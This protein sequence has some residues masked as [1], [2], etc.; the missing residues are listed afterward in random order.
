MSVAVFRL[1]DDLTEEEKLEPIACDVDDI[2]TKYA[3][4]WAEWAAGVADRGGAHWLQ[5]LT[6]G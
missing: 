2:R 1:P 4:Q 6:V 3:P 5:W